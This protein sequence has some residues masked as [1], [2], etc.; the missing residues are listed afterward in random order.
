MEIPL[1]QHFILFLGHPAY[2]MTAVLFALLL[3][4]GVGSALSHGLSLRLAL[5]LLVVLVVGYALGLPLLFAATL[6]LP[7]AGRAAVAVAAVAPAG[8]LMGIPFPQ[9][10]HCLE[11]Q[12]ASHVPWAWGV[13]GAMS[14]V[15]SVLAALLAL[16]FGFRVVFLC[17]ALCYAGAWITAPQKGGV[18]PGRSI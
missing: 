13:N 11:M 7:W 15:A 18:V 17:G 5:T 6:R 14:V 1:I 12:D 10:L 16:S 3:F 8:F 9:G 2:A 4:S